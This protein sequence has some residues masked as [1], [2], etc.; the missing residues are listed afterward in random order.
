MSPPPP[1]AG[2]SGA[3]LI[4]LGL[5]SAAKTPDAGYGYLDIP[6]RVSR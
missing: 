6:E 4:V 1:P 3:G 2:R 5:Q